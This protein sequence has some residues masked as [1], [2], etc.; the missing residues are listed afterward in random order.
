[1]HSPG[2]LIIVPSLL[3]DHVSFLLTPRQQA[4]TGIM[5]LPRVIVSSPPGKIG[6]L[7]TNG[8]NEKYDWYRFPGTGSTS[9]CYYCQTLM[10]NSFSP[11]LSGPCIFRP[12]RHNDLGHFLQDASKGPKGKVYEEK[13]HKYQLHYSERIAHFSPGESTYVSFLYGLIT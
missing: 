10:V 3:P 4:R 7:L 13:S 12:V 5:V 6:L 11:M 1:M 9:Y 2:D 8:E